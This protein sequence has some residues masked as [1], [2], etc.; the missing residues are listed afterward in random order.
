MLKMFYLVRCWD[1]NADDP[2]NK[3]SMKYYIIIIGISFM[4]SISN[5]LVCNDGDVVCAFMSADAN[6]IHG[7][8]TMRKKNL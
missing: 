4:W 2:L 5:N 1:R 3:H 8:Y 7:I 6:N